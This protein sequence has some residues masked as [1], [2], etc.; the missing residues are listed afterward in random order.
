MKSF[1]EGKRVVFICVKS[2]NFEGLIVNRLS[3]MGAIVRYFDERP[4]NTLYEK[5]IIR[6][7]KR[8]LAKRIATYYNCILDKLEDFNP[9]YLFVIRGEVVPEFFLKTFK[10]RWIQAK[11]IFYNSDSFL[12]NPNPMKLLSYFNKAATFD[13]IDAKKN[14]LAYIPLFYDDFYINQNTQFNKR[15]LDLSFIGTLHSD[16]AVVLEKLLRQISTDSKIYIFFYTHGLLGFIYFIFSAKRLNLRVLKNLNFKPLSTNQTRNLFLNSKVIID[17]EHP[18]QSGLTSRTIEALGAR[19]K[20]ITTNRNIL[21]AD[22]Y[23]PKNIL[24]VNRNNPVITNEFISETPS[25]NEDV[26]KKYTLTN[27]LTLLLED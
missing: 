5:S 12:N 25:F 27:W 22:F 21:E 15:Q 24:L 3:D 10:N 14:N 13:I 2:F 19:C 17:T 11:M 4:T 8:L 1:L 16:R 7:K 23:N 20:L 26:R 18:K 6:F 9:D